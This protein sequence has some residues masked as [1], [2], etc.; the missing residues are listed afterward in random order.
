[1]SLNPLSIAHLGIGRRPIVAALLGIWDELMVVL[2][3]EV[4]KR[5]GGAGGGVISRADRTKKRNKILRQQMVEEG[6]IALILNVL[7]SQGIIR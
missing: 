3:E 7:V 4:K 1:M 5:R 6:E 2:T